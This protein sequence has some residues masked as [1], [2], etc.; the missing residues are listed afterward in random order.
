MLL[1]INYAVQE[2]MKNLSATS[3]DD[4]DPANELV[5]TCGVCNLNPATVVCVDCDPGKHFRFCAGCDHDE[6]SRPFGPVMRHKRY[7]LGEAPA[8]PSTMFCSRHPQEAA[9]LYSEASNEFACST[10][11]LEGD[12]SGRAA[13]FELVVEATKRMRVKVQKLTKYINV[14]S[15]E[16][17]DSKQN[18]ET[19][20]NSLEPASMTVKAN[21]TRTFSKLTE[22]LQERQRKLLENVDLEVSYYCQGEGCS[23]LCA[24][25]GLL[26]NSQVLLSF[27]CHWNV[28]D[29]IELD[30][31]VLE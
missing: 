6:H 28:I 22:I 14:R 25:N 21:I 27:K 10:C 26:S 20:L 11:Q 16:L 18:L 23:A 29:H 13:T 4:Q 12:W 8:P 17:S 3:N 24:H 9:S 5:A 2:I 1:P 19:I 31:L 30:P 7:P 15:K